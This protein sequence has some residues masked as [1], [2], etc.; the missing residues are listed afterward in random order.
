MSLPQLVVAHHARCS[1]VYSRQQFLATLACK[2]TQ[3]M[4]LLCRLL[5][6]F[7]QSQKRRQYSNLLDSWSLLAPTIFYSQIQN[8]QGNIPC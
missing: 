5:A 2:E 7:K 8:Q 6:S 3:A 4:L 1:R